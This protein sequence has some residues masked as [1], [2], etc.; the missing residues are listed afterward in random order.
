MS[1]VCLFA[2]KKQNGN[3]FRTN[4]LGSGTRTPPLERKSKLSALGK[5]FKP[6]KWKRK[7][8]SDKLEAVSRSEYSI[9][10]SQT[11]TKVFALLLMSVNIINNVCF[12]FFFLAL[13]RKISV[14]ANR[15]ELV[16][17]GILLPES[18]FAPISEPGENYLLILFFVLLF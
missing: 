5:F 17:K 6:W 3:A 14:R 13:E 11:Q 16:Q 1:F 12:C 2:A 10:V 18:Q 7:K 15:D 9:H 4:S 8:K